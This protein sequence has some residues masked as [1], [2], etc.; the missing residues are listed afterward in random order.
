MQ[1]MAKINR[2]RRIFHALSG[3]LCLLPKTGALI[4]ALAVSF[5]HTS[6]VAQAPRDYDIDDDGLIDITTVE[7]LN[8]MRFD[9]AGTGLSK[10]DSSSYR[11]WSREFGNNQSSCPGGAGECLGYELTKDLD[12]TDPASYGGGIVLPYYTDADRGGPIEGFQPIGDA[13]AR[14]GGKLEGNGHTIYNLFQNDIAGRGNAGLFGGISGGTDGAAGACDKGCV[15][16]LGVTGSIT[17]GSGASVPASGTNANRIGGI[18]GL[19]NGQGGLRARIENSWS[20]VRIEGGNEVGSLVGFG[21]GLEVVASYATGRARVYGDGAAAQVTTNWAGGLIGNLDGRGGSFLEDSYATGYVDASDGAMPASGGLLGTNSRTSVPIRRS[22]STAR[23]APADENGGG[24]IGAY[25]GIDATA[26]VW[27]TETSRKDNA[28][29]NGIAIAGISGH[30]TAELQAPTTRADI[31]ANWNPTANERWDFGA[32]SQ[33]PALKVDFN[34]DGEPTWQ[35]FGF[36]LREGPRDLIAFGIGGHAALAWTAPPIP[37]EWD[38]PPIITYH[39][40]RDEAALANDTAGTPSTNTIYVDDSITAG[41]RYAYHVAAV[42]HGGEAARS[43]TISV[44]VLRIT[45]TDATGDVNTATIAENATA[46]VAATG[47]MPEVRDPDGNVVSDVTWGLIDAEDLFEISSASGVITLIADNTLDYETSTRHTVTVTAEADGYITGALELTINVLNVL[48]ELRIANRG[49][50]A[51]AIAENATAGA[52]VPGIALTVSDEGGAAVSGVTWSLPY[53][54]GLFAIDSASG[55]ISLI[56][57]GS[58]DY[59]TLPNHYA[60][61]ARAAKD[62]VISIGLGLTIAEADIDDTLPQLRIIDTDTTGDAN[63]ATIA[64]NA[65]AD[66]AI[67]GVTLAAQDPAGVAVSSATWSLT[68][69]SGLFAI[70]SADGAITLAADNTLNYEASTRHAVTV[71][72]MASGYASSGVTLTINVLN[73]LETLTI[74]NGGNGAIELAENATTGTAVPGIAL[75]TSDES[76]NAV[77]GAEW[78]LTDD[79]GGLFAITS[80]TGVITLEGALN[81][82]AATQ[83]AVMAQ[84]TKDGIDS[85]ILSLSIGVTNVGAPNAPETL[86]IADS[87]TGDNTIAE[88][89]PVGT[90]VPGIAL[91]ASDEGGNLISGVEWSLSNDAGGRFAI[92]TGGEVTVAGAL[93]YETDTSHAIEARASTATAVATLSLTIAVE[94]VPETLTVRDRNA[95]ANTI[96]ENAGAGSRVL[97][98]SLEAK[99]EANVAVTSGLVWSLIDNPNGLFSVDS[100]GIIRLVA[101]NS[102]DYEASSQHTV[103]VRVSKEGIHSN[104]ASLVISVGDINEDIAIVDITDNDNLA[105]V[106]ESAATGTAVSGLELVARGADGARLSVIWSLPNNAGGLFAIDGSSGV[107]AVAAA[108]DYETAREHRLRVRATLGGVSAEIEAEVRVENVLEALTIA[109]GG[110]GAIEIAENA[111]VGAVVPGIALTASDEGGNLISGAEWSL[112]NDAGGRFAITTGG[113]VTVAGALDYETDTSHAIEARASTATAVATLSLTIAVENVPETLTITDSDTTDNTVAENA[114]VGAVVAGIALTASDE[115]GNLISGAEWSL[116]ND[117]GGRFAITTGG[118]VTVAGA[119]DY[120]TDT[121]HAIEAR[122][123]TATAVATLS[124]TIAVENVPETLTIT[125]SDTTDNTIAENAPVGAVVAG[126]ALTASDE[127][128]NLI[129]GAEWSLSND[130]GGRFAITTGGEVTVAGALDYETDTSHAIEARASTATAVATL[131]LTIAVENV[132]ETLTITDSDTTDNTVAE[133]APVGAVVAGIALTASDEGGNLISGAEW[134][135]SNDAG[136]RFAITTGGEVTVAGALD[137]ETDTSHAIEARASTATAVATLSLTIAVENVPETL[138]IT[139]SDITDNT[140]A[141]NAPVG[142]VVAGIALTASDEGGNLISGAEWSLSNDAGGRFAITTGGEVTVA[143]ALDYETDTSHA[144]E[145]RA[146]TATAVA[147]LS[148]TIAVENVPE[149]LTIT[150]SDTTDNTVAENAPVGAVVAGIALTASDEGG[151]LIS[152]AEWSLSNDAGGR[153]AITTGGEVTVAGALDYETDTSHAIEARASTATA[154]ATLSLTIAVENVPETLTITDS[155]ITD[156]TVAENA[157]VGAVVAGIALTA[158]DEGGNLISGAEWSLSNDAGGRFAITTGG[159]VTV[160]GALDYETDTSHA[161]EARASTATAVATLSLTIAVENVPETLTITDSDTTDNTVAENAPVGAVVAGIALTASDEGG[162]LIS[163]A[164]WSLSNDAGGRFAI[165]TGGE[166]TVAG[167]L[168]YETDTSHAIEARAS[169]ATAVATLSLTIAVENVP[170]TLTVRDRNADANTIAENAGAGSRVL[171]I[172]LEAKDEA[173]VA[174]TSGLVWSLIDNPN[175]LFSV[176]SAGIIRLVAANSLDYEASSQHTVTV[177]VSKEG[178]HSNIAS[179]V[180]SVGDINE[181]IAIVDITDNDNLARVSESAATGTAVSGLELVARGADGARLSVIW[182]LPNNA[183]GLFAIDGSSGV[184][185]VAAALDYETA[186]EHRLRVRA[187]LGGVSAEIEAEVRVEN[188]LEALTIANGGSGAIE[189][190]E[191]APVGAVVPGIA[192]TASDEGGNLISGAEWSLT[193]D[194]GNLFA[195]TSNTG[196]IAVA[197]ELNYEAATQHAVMAQATKDGIDSNILSLSIGVISV[198]VTNAPESLTI[199]DGNAGDNAIAENAPVGAV[200]PGIALTASDEGGAAVSGVEW[201]LTDD[202]GGLFSITIGGEVRVAAA[203]DF[204]TAQSHTITAQASTGTVVNTLALTIAVENVP[205]TLTIA[206]ADADAI[207][208]AENAPVGAAVPGIALTASD[209][210][211]AAVSG[212]EWSLTDDAGGLFAITSNTGVIAVAGELNYEAATQH[213]V[214]AQATKDGID[215]NQLTLAIAVTDIDESLPQLRITDADATGDANTATIAENATTGTAIADVTLAAQDPGGASVTGVTWSLTDPAHPDLFAIDSADGAIT[216]VASDTLDYE[217]ARSHSVTVT[218]ETAGYQPAVVTLTINILNV[219]ETLTIANAGI[220]A[221]EIA[222]NATTGTM[223]PGITLTAT[224]EGGNAVSGVEWNLTDDAG[225]LFA[226]TSNTGA[227]TTEGELNYEASTQ[228]PVTVRA[229]KDGID[230]NEPNL[231]IVVTNVAEPLTIIDSDTAANA[232]AE[233]AVA[234]MPVTGIALQALDE[235]GDAVS[236]VTWSIASAPPGLFAIDADGAIRL[237]ASNTLDYETSTAHT[238]EARATASGIRSD[239]L[240]LTIMVT[241]FDETIVPPTVSDADPAPNA[242]AENSTDTIVSGIMLA[243]TRDGNPLSGIAWILTDDADGL[244]AIAAAT[245]VIKTAT[246]RAPDYEAAASHGVTAVAIAADGSIVALDLPIEVRNVAESLTIVDSDTDANAIAENAPPGTAATGIALRA[247][248]DGLPLTAGEGFLWRLSDDAGGLFAIT[249]GGEVTAAGALDYE[250]TPTHSV[251]VRAVAGAVVSDDLTLTIAVGNVPESLT[252]IDSD[253]SANT[254]AENSAIGT[255]VTGINL[256]AHEGSLPLTAGEDFLWSLSDDAGGLFSITTG[257]EVTAAGALDYETATSHT[258]EARASTGAVVDTL[259]L[260]IN[261]LN[262]PEPLTIIDSDTAANAI[263]ENAVANMPVTGIALQALDEAGDAVSAVTWSI[264]SA[265]PGLFAIDADGAI[266]LS[267]S[268]TLDY[269]TSTAH[270]AEARATASGIRSDPLPLTIMVTDFDETI[271]PPTVSDADPAPNAIAENSTDTIVSG[272]MLAATRDGNPLSGIAWI[273]TDDADGLFAIAAATGVIKTATDRAPDYE[274][275]ASHGVTAV[276]IAADG[277][278]VALDLPIEVRNVAESLTIV[279]SDTDANAIAENAPP[280][281]AVTGIALRAHEGSLPL[282][283]GAGFAWEMTDTAADLFAIDPVSGEITA[284]GALDHES[285]PTHSVTVRAVAGAVV[286]NDLALTINILDAPDALTIVDSDATTNTVVEN[287]ATGTAVTGITL[288]ARDE[289][290]MP[291][292]AVTWSVASAPAGLFAISSANSA[293]LIVAGALDYESAPTH[294]VT[295]RAVAGAVVSNDLALTISVLNVAEALT[296]A[297]SGN[298]AIE[299]A[300][301]APVGTAVPGIALRAHE[302]GLPLTGGTDFIW[303]LSDD[304]GGLFA[305]APDSGVVTLAGELDYETTPTHTITARA[306]TGAVSATIDVIIAVIDIDETPSPQVAYTA[307]IAE[308]ATSGTA[309]AGVALAAQVVGGATVGSVTWSLGDPNDPDL[310][311]ISAGGGIITLIASGAL[312]YETAHSHSVTVTA[313]AAG[314][315]PVTMPLRIRVINVLESLAIADS[316]ATTNTVVENAATG[317]AVTG[318]TLTVRDEGNRA[319]SG[320]TW[321]LASAPNGLFAIDPDSGEV[322]VAGALD[323]E[324]STA[325][326]VIVRATKDAVASDDLEMTIEVLN[327]PTDDDGTE[328]PEPALKLRLRLFLE[329]PLR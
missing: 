276:A 56:A 70:D 146:S 163:G 298:G 110:S 143:G 135:L 326:T 23:I 15:S 4:L 274:A 45:D 11:V 294:S 118:E 249:T 306:S 322:T 121:S 320:M 176:D 206:N 68:D 76:G 123:S 159:E 203:L 21:R 219:L 248:E 55:V 263:A 195:I 97:G 38:P 145:A 285:T 171:G 214:V 18:A 226:I 66:T 53:A 41:A 61:V 54:S 126:I 34:G 166:V 162:N 281:T 74:A 1:V 133:N 95:D 272:I 213:A 102:L 49:S 230:S 125:D 257:G 12:F 10:D 192:L 314:Y 199:A 71:T 114:P 303:G 181:D 204:E 101:A 218:A 79:A 210:G 25:V 35:E 224:D 29:G 180:I 83:H 301:D 177:R 186:R 278:I 236:A 235:A 329:G 216:L 112:S 185:A 175:G 42:I 307:T 72:A 113:E 187:T 308:D 47:V 50:G 19:M 168:D 128:G 221:I 93:D 88:N 267:A 228:H 40:Y 2:A 318:I 280:G 9:P 194:A 137:Y 8:V 254:I 302:D 220:G 165:T 131:S 156:N 174:V 319:V 107:I 73:V 208:L 69:P 132:P 310:F 36:Q 252:I 85:N 238:A 127:G 81:Y 178:I 91:T 161:I 300:E 261:I 324:A 24:V 99:D 117:A 100:A 65:T 258:I 139:D 260:T 87:D 84:A 147:T 43:A 266:R 256:Q 227:I 104:I 182:S 288:Q 14:W 284:A 149:T 151:N 296:V 141:E 82:E 32:A 197:G 28:A 27:D 150:D 120:E 172:S 243:A 111:P 167:A 142:A 169:T 60:V 293:L 290:G 189:I 26:V 86:T 58:L 245:G 277:S 16:N 289:M 323:Y 37:P 250:S 63:T 44:D 157:P 119:L 89:A 251:T 328:P 190:A 124:L 22:Y 295:V 233:N 269:E 240:P 138:T 286:S 287:A 51:I 193:D 313:A 297:N 152:G 207:E 108:L 191:N 264:A 291:V 212:V 140:V 312:D 271:V 262:A 78:S 59:E 148:L 17:S 231:T 242:I 265:P 315:E 283:S 80:N 144:I 67:A 325:H 62:G 184:I 3:F 275:A 183:G 225:G 158:S 160:A 259:T 122:A 316:N 31:Y 232:I 273:L 317:T 247:H 75:T 48:E 173:N 200:V 33:Y 106:S 115:G 6:A 201:S 244:F 64:E 46:G 202:A 170:E 153:F 164:E 321:S 130:A 20:A 103:T 309:I 39:I 52:V 205:E 299:L 234:N 96:A 129:S 98:I 179:L 215:S 237:S 327:D 136:G 134:S 304:A 255:A 105:R 7:Q 246:D 282:T 94:N 57:S 211:G 223:V 209:E 92:T 155:D 109:N 253:T 279:D 305:I 154:V 196:V 270:T 5:F 90:V 116:S 217:T 268:N 292:T 239:P 13:F 188:V 222:E 77:S 198:G 30:A 229:T 241:D 311:A